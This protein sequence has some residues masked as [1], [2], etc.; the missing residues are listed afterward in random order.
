MHEVNHRSKNLLV[1]VEA[2]PRQTVAVAPEDFIERFGERLRALAANQ[3]L[4]VKNEWRGVNLSELVHSQLAHLG[5]LIGTRIT[6]KGPSLIITASA[7]QTIGMALHELA[8]NAGKYGAL[9]N[10][11]GSVRVEWELGEAEQGLETFRSAGVR[12]AGPP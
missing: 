8:T 9:S 3:D 1:L 10:S 2:M 12:A 11:D 4:L 6:L 7:S 5:D